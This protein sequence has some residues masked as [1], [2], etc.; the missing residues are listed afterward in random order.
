M[1]IDMFMKVEGVMVNQ[2]ILTTKTGLT[3]KV[4]TGVQSNLVQ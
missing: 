1:A 3:S 4:L 2:K